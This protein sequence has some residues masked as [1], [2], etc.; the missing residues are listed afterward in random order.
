MYAHTWGEQTNVHVHSSIPD[1]PPLFARV[2]KLLPLRPVEK[3]IFSTFPARWVT[4]QAN[5]VTE[6][7][8]LVGFVIVLDSSISARKTRKS[9]INAPKIGH[10]PEHGGV[11]S[12]FNF[13]DREEQ[14]QTK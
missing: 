8:Q 2:S 1:F 10:A 9:C 4:K 13:G 6:I 5:Q 3:R 12:Q 7:L 11:D 14:K